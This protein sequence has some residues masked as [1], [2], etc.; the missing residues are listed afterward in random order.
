MSR[1]QAR[2]IAFALDRKGNPSK[3]IAA[4]S[5]VPDVSS[6]PRAVTSNR[7]SKSNGGQHRGIP[8][9]VKELIE[10]GKME[11]ILAEIDADRADGGEWCGGRSPKR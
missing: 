5:A 1:H 8:V 10:A 7:T 2:G 4:L 6:M 11:T 9:I 3:R